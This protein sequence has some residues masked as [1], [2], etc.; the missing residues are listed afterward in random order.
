MVDQTKQDISELLDSIPN[1][2]GRSRSTSRTPQIYT[3]A[4][5][6]INILEDNDMGDVEDIGDNDDELDE[7]RRH[8]NGLK[9]ALMK[10]QVHGVDWMIDR[11][12]NKSSNGGI[13]ADVS[14][15]KVSKAHRIWLTRLHF[16]CHTL[17]V[18]FNIGCM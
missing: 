17:W 18:I 12:A 13:L 14:A 4:N 7:S 1:S 10:H 3:D 6:T 5:G 15:E 16:D 9:I 11:E 8:I 2:F